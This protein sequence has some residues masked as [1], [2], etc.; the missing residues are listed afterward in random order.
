MNDPTGPDLETLYRLFDASAT[1]PDHAIL[2]AIDVPDPY[3]KLLVHPHH[4]TVT[5]EEYY[6]G[7]VNVHVLDR[8]T[9]GSTYSRMILLTTATGRVVQF[10]VVRIHLDDCSESV[11]AAI[12]EE[13]TPLGRVLIKHDVL[14]RIEPTAFFRITAAD[15]LASWFGLDRPRLTYGRLGIIHCDNRPAIELLEIL[16]PIGP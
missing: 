13:K 15:K 4:M 3:R 14:R 16:A 5:V 1:L 12:V 6:A 11:R 2:P 10:G 9:E 8:K 7:P